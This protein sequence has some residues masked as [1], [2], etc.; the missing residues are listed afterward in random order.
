MKSKQLVYTALFAALGVILPQMFHVFGSVSGRVLLPMHI[1]VLLAGFVCGPISGLLVG[2]ISVLVSHVFT[3][4]PPV[5]ILFFMIA[6]LPVYGLMAGLLFNKF[7]LNMILSLILAMVAGRIVVGIMI[8]CATSLFGIT[9]PPFI[10]VVGMTIAGLP[11][12]ALQIVVI[13][14]V[15]LIMKKVGYQYATA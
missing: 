8:I 4:M 2:L 13:P 11:G 7:R 1:P 9:L 15:M 6:E 12:I 10:N 5:P 14:S 3:G